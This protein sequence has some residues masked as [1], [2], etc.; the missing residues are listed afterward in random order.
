MTGKHIQT[1]IFSAVLLVFFFMTVGVGIVFFF[2]SKWYVQYTAEKENIR[3]IHMVQSES[4]RLDS[5]ADSTSNE[6]SKE[7]AR[8]H[9]KALLRSVRQQ[10][11]DQPFNG[12]VLVL[13]SKQKLI[14]PQSDENIYP[15]SKLEEQCRQMLS[16]GELTSARPVRI[17]LEGSFWFIGLYTFST[18]YP[19]RAK[20]FIAVTQIPDSTVFWNYTWPLFAI[21]LLLALIIS[22]LFVWMIAKKISSPIHHLCQQIQQINGTDDAQIHDTYSLCEL[23]SLKQSYNQMEKKIRQSEEEIRQ[24][25]QNA[26]HDLKTPLASIIGYSQGITSGVIKDPQKAAS[27]ILSESLRMTDLVESILSLSK[28][29]SQTFT[30]YPVDLEL[31]EF[32][33]EC[34]DIM[35]TTRK[36]CKIHLDFNAPLMVHTDPELLKRI[37]QN[38]LSN[39]LRYANHE[40]WIHMTHTNDRL[41]LL[42]HDD[43][44]GF[45]EKDLPHIFERFYKGEG[46]KNGIGLSIVRSGIH[47]LGGTIEAGNLTP[48]RHGAFYRISLPIFLKS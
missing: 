12:T 23:E 36:D 31:S 40:I 19:V 15:V 27:I 46:G 2:S 13:N 44:S 21:I 29:D 10:L 33:D 14:F 42:I 8:E 35:S 25:F 3:L 6:I 1:R 48:P 16:S 18:D 9:S 11:R 45:R 24:F 41:V 34:V 43:G 28:M 5:A 26:S 4:H 30:L 17:F 7:A 37:I 22:S 47:Y 32:L 39:C 20:D 38:I